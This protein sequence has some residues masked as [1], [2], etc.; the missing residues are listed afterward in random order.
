M[1]TSG[2][3]IARPHLQQRTIPG[4]AALLLQPRRLQ[5]R[6]R[7]QQELRALLAR[8]CTPRKGRGGVEFNFNSWCHRCW[9]H[10][11]AMAQASIDHQ[12]SAPKC[13]PTTCTSAPASTYA[14]IS[15]G[16]SPSAALPLRTCRHQPSSSACV[17]RGGQ[18]EK[19]QGASA[20]HAHGGIDGSQQLLRP[21]HKLV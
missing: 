17:H 13:F 1:H 4:A 16:C 18:G 14:A 12:G 15:Q 6:R 9:L 11:N 19:G 21:L 3:P 2:L 7:V 5:H 10:S 8:H 20:K